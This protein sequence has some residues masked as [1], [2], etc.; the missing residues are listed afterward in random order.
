MRPFKENSLSAKIVHVVLELEK[1]KE[2]NAKLKRDKQ[3]LEALLQRKQRF[4]VRV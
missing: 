3:C 2:E 4:E 1:V